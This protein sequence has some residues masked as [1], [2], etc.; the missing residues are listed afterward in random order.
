MPRVSETTTA[1]HHLVDL[2]N[3]PLASQ[4]ACC[5][6]PTFVILIIYGH[7]GPALDVATTEEK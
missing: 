4:T 2:G 7:I 3:G 1:S 5:A 6:N